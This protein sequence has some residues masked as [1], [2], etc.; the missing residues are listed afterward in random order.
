MVGT[1]LF[2]L[3]LFLQRLEPVMELF[4]GRGAPAAEMLRLFALTVPQAFPFTI[5]IGVLTGILVAV[6]RLSSDNEILAMTACG[7]RG[8]SLTAPVALVATLGLATC[9]TTTCGSRLGRCASRCALP[10]RSAFHLAGS[11]VQ[12]RVFIEDFPEQVIWVQDVVPGEGV[13]WK[14]IFIADMRTPEARGSLRGFNASPGGPRITLASEAFVLPRPE[15]NRVQIRF[16]LTT[17]YEQS[18]DPARY[19]AV[20]SETTD[21]VLQARP[22]AVR[23]GRAPLR[24]N[25]HPDV[26]GRGEPG[27]RIASS[28]PAP[29]A[30]RP[31]AGVLDPASGGQAPWRFPRAGRDDP[32]ASC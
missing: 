31:A 25:G 6:G 32:R 27:R 12:P 4:V 1:L 10:I 8:R 28:H 24:Q 5:P 3:V 15:Q 7:V 2:T 18:S 9:A 23:S 22:S 19:L 11:E 16:P 29:R 21:Q 14:G 13:Q 17:T 26:D 30:V 20:R